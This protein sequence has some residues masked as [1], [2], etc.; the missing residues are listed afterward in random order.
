MQKLHIYF[1][2]E[3]NHLRKERSRKQLSKNSLAKL[4]RMMVVWAECWNIE[5]GSLSLRVLS[6]FFFF[7]ERL[8]I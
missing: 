7:K 1:P 4:I 6:S 5:L 3:K 2:E 8:C